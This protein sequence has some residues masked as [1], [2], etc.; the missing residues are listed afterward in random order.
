MSGQEDKTKEVN[1]GPEKG[2]PIDLNVRMDSKAL[3]DVMERL[4]DE[5]QKRKVAEKALEEI[6]GKLVQTEGK[7]TLTE[8][9]LTEAG[10]K[11]SQSEG[12]VEEKTTEAD[13]LKSKLQ[14]IAEKK[15]AEKKKLIEDRAKTLIVDEDRRKIFLEKVQTPKDLQATEFMLDTLAGT[16][17]KG[18]EEI[19]KI[20]KKAKDELVIKFPDA[21]VKIEAAKSMDEIDILKTE[22]KPLPI[23]PPAGVAPLQGQT[24][25]STGGEREGGYENYEAM[26]RDLRKKE[27]SGNPEE[28]AEAKQILDELFKKWVNAVKKNYEGKAIGGLQMEGMKQP[29]VRDMTGAQEA[30]EDTLKRRGK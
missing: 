23:T 10:T 16:L 15:F 20:V 7:L 6:Q 21:K 12:K 29:S 26:I 19:N 9:K 17:E 22:L 27:H 3:E 25:T 5:E 13:E 24:T 4:K 1:K 11:L 18:Q 30:R 28:V 14:L 2:T 8:G